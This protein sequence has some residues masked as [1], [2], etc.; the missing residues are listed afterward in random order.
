M[1][2]QMQH[3]KIEFSNIKFL[4][5][6]YVETNPYTKIQMQKNKQQTKEKKIMK[7][8]GLRTFDHFFDDLDDVFGIFPVGNFSKGL[9]SNMNIEE[10]N[11]AYLLSI[12]VPGIDKNAIKITIDNGYVSISYQKEEKAE[13]KKSLRKSWSMESFNEEYAI[14]TDVK[15]D[16]IS[17]NIDNGVLTVILEKDKAFLKKNEPKS[18]EIKSV[19]Q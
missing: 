13:D 18:I 4:Y 7:N 16:S 1:V 3:Q 12:A 2:L 14:P 6:I 11:D 8:Y 19:E 15:E 17:A 10:T 9:N 5:N